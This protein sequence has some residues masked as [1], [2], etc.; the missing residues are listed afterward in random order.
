MEK[1]LRLQKAWEKERKRM[2]E[3]KTDNMQNKIELS[4]GSGELQ[5]KREKRTANKLR[6]LQQRIFSESL[7][8]RN[9]KNS[10]SNF[11]PE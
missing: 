1:R 9:E 5:L 7:L 8:I 4:K 10:Q 11:L 3:S 6:D 2:E